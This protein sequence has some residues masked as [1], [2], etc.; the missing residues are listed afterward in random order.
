MPPPKYPWETWRNGRTHVLTEEQLGGKAYQQM[1]TQLH[2]YAR[3]NSDELVTLKVTTR[4]DR[5]NRT[6]TFHFDTIRA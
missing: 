3:N 2:A 4:V 1:A 6:L 5:D